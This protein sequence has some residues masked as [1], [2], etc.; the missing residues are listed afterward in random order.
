M[1]YTDFYTNLLNEDTPDIELTGKTVTANNVPLKNLD[2]A[3]VEKNI[4]MFRMPHSN[5][6]FGEGYTLIYFMDSEQS[7]Q[8]MINNKIP[9]LTVP[10]GTFTSGGSPITDIW[11]NRFQKPGTEHILGVIEG[12]T[13]KDKIYIDMIT[14]RPKYRRNTIAQK[15]IAI[16]RKSFPNAKISYSHATPAGSKFFTSYQKNI[17]PEQWQGEK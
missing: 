4:V 7:A 14:V 13:N 1:K 12:W 6:F 10:R 5:S 2:L 8:D 3:A 9:Y 16:I 11:K 15:M 17:P